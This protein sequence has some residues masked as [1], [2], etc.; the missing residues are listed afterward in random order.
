M[1]GMNRL[2]P[3]FVVACLTLGC[4]SDQSAPDRPTDP[5]PP[6]TPAVLARTPSPPGAVVFI[7]TPVDGSTVN[8]PVQVKFGISGMGVAPSGDFAERTGHHH[9]L[10]DVELQEDSLPIPTSDNYLHFGK[11]QTEASLEL[12]P[13][14]HTLQLVLGDGGHIPHDPPVMSEPITIK[15]E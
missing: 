14:P 2:M 9:L 12:E 6:T 11:G 15:V 10:V 3:A 13:G 8:S 1:V 4:E 7:I 5:P